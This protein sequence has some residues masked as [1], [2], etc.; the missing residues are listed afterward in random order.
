[1]E[2]KQIAK[3]FTKRR[4]KAVRKRKKKKEFRV[5]E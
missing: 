5:Y 3:D 1:M 2:I 4:R